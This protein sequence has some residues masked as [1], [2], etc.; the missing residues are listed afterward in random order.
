M[1][2]IWDISPQPPAERRFTIHYG[3]ALIALLSLVM[4]L[5]IGISLLVSGADDE[6]SIVDFTGMVI[7][8]MLWG[9]FWTVIWTAFA[10]QHTFQG[11]RK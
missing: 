8:W 5:W 1:M 4:T 6:G 3:F 2:N 10:I 9:G 11:R 7:A